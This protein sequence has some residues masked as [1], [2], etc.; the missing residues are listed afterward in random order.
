MYN[1]CHDKHFIIVCKACMYQ[2]ALQCATTLH[3]SCSMHGCD[4]Q[5]AGIVRIAMLVEFTQIYERWHLQR[6][7][8]LHQPAAPL[9]AAGKQAAA[10]AFAW[11][12]WHAT[13]RQQLS[14]SD[15]LESVNVRLLQISNGV[16]QMFSS[17]I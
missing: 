8:S 7:F 15:L 10:T 4:I 2:V 9:R 5:A 6:S 11:H 17:I 13:T 16:L 12:D 14:S 1:L 3:G